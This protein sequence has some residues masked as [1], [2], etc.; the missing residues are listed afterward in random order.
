[1]NTLRTFAVIAVATFVALGLGS[2]SCGGKGAAGTCPGYAACGGDPTGDWKLGDACVNLTIKP[3][4][5]LSLPDQLKQPQDVTLE[6]PQ[7]T[8][9]TSGNWCS[10]LIYQP[11]DKNAPVKGVILW[12]GPLGIE[13]GTLHHNKADNSYLG[14][15]TWVATEHVFFPRAC[16]TNYGQE[17]PAPTC[18]ELEAAL[19]Q[20]FETYP[21]FSKFHC[22]DEGDGCGCDYRYQ[23]VSADNGQ[24]EVDPADPSVIIHHS[25][26][27]SE[28]QR[29]SFCVS[30]DG[31]TLQ[32]TGD[33]GTSLLNQL[34]LRSLSY[35]KMETADTGANDA[36]ASDAGPSDARANDAGANDASGNDVGPSDAGA[37][38]ARA[39]GAGTDGGGVDG[40]AADGAGPDGN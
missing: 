5:Q 11:A 4:Q 25:K 19:G 16:I 23:L 33:E 12:H 3:Y 14:V 32:M 34:G 24:W 35:T 36:G 13:S 20:Y 26:K 39:D 15:V 27:T 31:K 9:T 6:P 10:D 29:S 8:P 1:M 21:S 17:E 2:P 40:P 37:N 18:G 22:T 38:D 30:A 7:P 28:P